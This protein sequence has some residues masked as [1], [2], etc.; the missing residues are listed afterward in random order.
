MAVFTDAQL[1]ITVNQSNQT[2]SVLVKGHVLLTPND[3][4]SF[5]VECSMLGDDVLLDD[6]LFQ[7]PPKGIQAGGFGSSASFEFS[8]TE[9]LSI[10]NEDVI[11]KDEIYADLVLK[12]GNEIGPVVSKIKTNVVQINA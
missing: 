1:S 11:G 10:L 3:V 9:Q 12:K 7:Y 5:V 2:A 4:G 6:K 8:S